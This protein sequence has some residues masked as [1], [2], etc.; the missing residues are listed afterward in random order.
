MS[1]PNNLSQKQKEQLGFYEA[2][3]YK[4]YTPE[5]EL[6]ETPK[7]QPTPL[8]EDIK[9][10]FDRLNT[11]GLAGHRDPMCVDLNYTKNKYRWNVVPEEKRVEGTPQQI[12]RAYQNWYLKDWQQRSRIHKILSILWWL[13]SHFYRKYFAS[14]DYRFYY[15]GLVSFLART[16]DKFQK[17]Q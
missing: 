7:T 2:Y 13:P 9:Q 16:R 15:N 1:E 12:E 3:E 8:P 4:G 6:H 17:T 5:R 10:L 11:T 14:V